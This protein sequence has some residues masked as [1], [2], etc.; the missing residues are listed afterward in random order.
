MPA[1]GA[2][3]MLAVLIGGDGSILEAVFVLLSILASADVAD[4]ADTSR[5]EWT[6]LLPSALLQPTHVTSISLH[7]SR[8]ACRACQ[9]DPT[10]QHTFPR[11]CQTTVCSMRTPDSCDSSREGKL[12]TTTS[13]RQFDGWRVLE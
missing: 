9:A 12:W 10:W 8:L 13:L 7:N 6:L 3:S 5:S 1:F 4:L 11:T 2:T